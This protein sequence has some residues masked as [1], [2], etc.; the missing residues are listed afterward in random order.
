[1]KHAELYTAIHEAIRNVFMS[2]DQRIG[3]PPDGACSCGADDW[4]V[5]EHGIDRICRTRRNA[6]DALVVSTHGW[7]D[8]SEDSVLTILV[9]ASCDTV[10]EC[11]DL[12]WQ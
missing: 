6:G 12:E 5:V 8:Y 10:Y 9:C 4:L 7:D 1:M 3:N 2:A 11:P